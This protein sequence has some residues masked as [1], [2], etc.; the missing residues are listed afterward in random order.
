MRVAIV[1]A[2]GA[3]GRKFIECLERRNFPVTEIRLYASPQSLGKVL[4]FR[5][6]PVRVEALA[7]PLRGV[8]LALFS[9]GAAVSREWA[10][11]FAAAGA[12]VVDNSSAWRMDPEV[13]LVV[14]EVNPQEIARHRGI[15]ANPNC[16]TIQLVLALKPLHDRWRVRR[17]VVSTYQA[18][19]GAGARASAELEHE[20]RSWVHD[21]RVFRRQV[22]PRPIAFNLIPQI[23][24]KEA[25]LDDGFTVEERKMIDETRKILGDPSIRVA[26]TCVRVPVRNAHSEAVAVETEGPISVREACEAWRSWPGLALRER[27]DEFPTPV[28][29]SGKDEVFVGRIRQDPSVEHGLLFWVVA[30][31]LLKGA[32]LNAVQIAE[33]LVS[34]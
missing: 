7:E 26:P 14:P 22:F 30:D 11:R 8:D 34:R 2:T 12:V 28:E 23:P 15:I 24:Q 16:S 33:R 6:T 10:P 25:F 32:A 31:N 1:G 3:V 9:A 18:V 4:H 17:V 21:D 29:V 13:P 5:N 20:V 19:S 27:S